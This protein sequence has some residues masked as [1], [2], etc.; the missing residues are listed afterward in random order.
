MKSTLVDSNVLIDLFDEGSDWRD[1]S[2]A[3]LT[4]CAARARW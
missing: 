3:M 2:D 4:R 1:W